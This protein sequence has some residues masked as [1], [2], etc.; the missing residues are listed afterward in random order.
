MRFLSRLFSKSSGPDRQSSLR[1]IHPN[2]REFTTGVEQI[3]MQ[4]PQIAFIPPSGLSPFNSI[5]F[6]QKPTNVRIANP[7]LIGN[8]GMI[9]CI[10]FPVGEL[11]LSERVDLFVSGLPDRVIERTQ[12]SSKAGIPITVL[13]TVGP[14]PGKAKECHTMHCFFI[15][16]AGEVVDLYCIGSSEND[17]RTMT[18]ALVQ[19]L[20][21]EP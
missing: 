18:N 17:A 2:T 21:F 9:T 20:R 16:R 12:T 6:E 19:S 3:I 14:V 13:H 5:N 4:L 8:P 7:S 1:T 10:V 15:N 11:S